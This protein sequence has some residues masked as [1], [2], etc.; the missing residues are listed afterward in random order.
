MGIFIRNTIKLFLINWNAKFIYQ[1]KNFGFLSINQQ[2]F[3]S[4]TLKMYR[5]TLYIPP[6]IMNEF[7]NNILNFHMYILL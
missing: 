1:I 7:G 6:Y 2:V 4:I 5:Q 3:N